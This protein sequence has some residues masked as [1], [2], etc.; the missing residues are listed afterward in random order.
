MDNKRLKQRLV[1]AAVLVSLVVVFLPMLVEQSPAPVAHRPAVPER[2]SWQ[3]EG[4]DEEIEYQAPETPVAAP[5][6]TIDPAADDTDTDRP[7]Q[8]ARMSAVDAPDEAGNGAT[9]TVADPPRRSG[10]R[11]DAVVNKGDNLYRIFERHGLG[12]SQVRA[13]L[14]L[15]APADRLSRLRPGQH[16]QLQANPNGQLAYLE[17]RGGGQGALRV[18]RRGGKLVVLEGGQTPAAPASKGPRQPTT[19]AAEPKAAPR[20]R[21]VAAWAVQVAAVTELTRARRIMEGLKGKDYPAFIRKDDGGR[22]LWKVKV[23][24]ETRRREAV[25]LARRIEQETGKTGLLVVSYP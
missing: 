4:W 10:E 25:A 17:Y 18:E 13:L 9:A 1:G 15:G 19:A 14:A 3:F 6:V 5:S 8:R 11:V 12:A 16:I 24:P 20:D 7:D 23:G 22:K 21:S 2:P